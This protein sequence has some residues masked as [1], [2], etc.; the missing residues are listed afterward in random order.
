VIVFG[1]KTVPIV[2]VA[3]LLGFAVVYAPLYALSM[4]NNG[5]MNGY[6]PLDMQTSQP[7]NVS[8]T[9]ATESYVMAYNDR[10]SEAIPNSP[11]APFM[12]PILVVSIGIIVSATA[13]IYLKR[14]NPS[15]RKIA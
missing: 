10:I 8:G 1:L 15:F 5:A 11:A 2:I 14:K 9:N 6:G 7:K 3:V 13:Y 12:G 4:F